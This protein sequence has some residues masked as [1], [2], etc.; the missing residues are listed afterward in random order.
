[1]QEFLVLIFLLSLCVTEAMSGGPVWAPLL[2]LTA[3]LAALYLRRKRHQQRTDFV[4]QLKS[5]RRELRSGGTVVVDTL[6]LRY[7]TVLATYRLNIGA[8]LT[9]IVVPSRYHI[10]SGEE[11]G[12]SLLYSLLSVVSG[13]WAFPTGPLITLSLIKQNLGGGEKISVAALIDAP[14][15]AAFEG[16][17]VETPTFAV[18]RRNAE[19]EKP[20]RP[21]T[22]AGSRSDFMLDRRTKTPRNTSTAQRI[23]NFVNPPP[24]GVRLS[25]FVRSRVEELQEDTRNRISRTIAHR[26]RRSKKADKP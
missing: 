18:H 11:Q 17:Q 10:S 6:M 9:N 23:E 25:R 12:E 5:Y 19:T 24:P 22:G 26:K 20:E 15:L 2:I 13:W 14:L 4:N 1:M 7:G 21:S 3:Y 8:L 16:P